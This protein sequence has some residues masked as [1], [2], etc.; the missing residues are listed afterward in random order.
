MATRVPKYTIPSAY[1]RLDTRVT[2]PDSFINVRD[3][4]VA[5][6]NHNVQIA[7]LTATLA[8]SLDH[9]GGEVRSPAFV[10]LSHP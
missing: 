6:N 8:G 4:Q 1:I 9:S 10:E 3:Q 2:D 7:V 5:R